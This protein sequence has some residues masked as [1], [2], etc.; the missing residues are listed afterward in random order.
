MVTLAVVTLSR[1]RLSEAAGRWLKLAS[2]AV[3]L[4]LGFV[5]LLAPEWLG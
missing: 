3:M 2:G 4:A 1:R 5:L